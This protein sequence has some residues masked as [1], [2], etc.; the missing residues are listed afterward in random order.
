MTRAELVEKLC[1]KFP[2]LQLKDIDVAVRTILDGIT[3][4]LAQGGRVEVRGFGSFALNYKPARKGR[5][6][7]T[8]ITVMVPAKYSPHFKAGLELHERVDYQKS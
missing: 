1:F 3:N 6:P 5:N 7:K 4:T 2:A 8:G